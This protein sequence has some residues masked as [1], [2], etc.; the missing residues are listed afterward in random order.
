MKEVIS[1]RLED[2]LLDELNKFAKSEGKSRTAVIKEAIRF[3]LRHVHTKSGL[4]GFVPFSEYKR[5]NDELKA[6]LK[7]VSHLEARLVELKK[8]NELLKEKLESSKKKR[9]FF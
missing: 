1:V 5:V 4:D 7:Q 3:Y 6:L 2:S 9:W 8:E